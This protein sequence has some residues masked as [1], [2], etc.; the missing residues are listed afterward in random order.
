MPSLRSAE[1]SR[2]RRASQKGLQ[3]LVQKASKEPRVSEDKHSF[4]GLQPSPGAPKFFWLHFCFVLGMGDR[5][6]DVFPLPRLPVQ[7]L[8]KR[9]LNRGTQRRIHSRAAITRRANLRWD[10]PVVD[11]ISVLPLVQQDAIKNVLKKVS[12][13][14][15][16]PLD[17]C[18]QGAMNALR[19]AGSSYTEPRPDVG[20]VVDMKLDSLSLP[21]GKVAGVGLCDN[22]VGEVRDMVVDYENHLLQDASLSTDLEGE[23][24]KIKTY[25]D[26]LLS[27]KSGYMSFLKQLF[28]RGVLSFTNSCRGR[29]GA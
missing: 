5:Q 13:L 29:V 15:P 2:R 8:Q 26:P 1:R 22:L 25:N 21:S 9:F 6:R 28:K 19:T 17:A 3:S 24:A 27:S 4:S 10:S 11:D 18:S 12:Q 14:G 7:P 23:A 20:I 16:P